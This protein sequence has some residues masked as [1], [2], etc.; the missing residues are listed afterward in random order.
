MK[1]PQLILC[2]IYVLHVEAFKSPLSKS[3]LN[4]HNLFFQCTLRHVRC[5]LPKKMRSGKVRRNYKLAMFSYDI[6]NS[7]E[8]CAQSQR[9][10]SILGEESQRTGRQPS[11]HRCRL[12]CLWPPRQAQNEIRRSPFPVARIHMLFLSGL[13]WSVQRGTLLSRGPF[14]G[15]NLPLKWFRSERRRQLV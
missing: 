4:S 1:F 6:A 10:I 14:L 15:L 13:P 8:P 11:K 12:G 7:S 3:L 5:D 9:P 2:R